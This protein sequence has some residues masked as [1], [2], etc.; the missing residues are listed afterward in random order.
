MS[1]KADR[2][3]RKKERKAKGGS[4]ELW[5]LRAIHINN[6]V[7]CDKCGL[8]QPYLQ[9]SESVTPCAGALGVGC[10]SLYCRPLDEYEIP[11]LI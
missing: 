8:V 5:A 6:Q 10:G 1:S 4:D 7:V 3:A 9:G 11:D 2:R